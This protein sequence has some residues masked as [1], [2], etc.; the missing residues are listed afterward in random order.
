MQTD[1]AALEPESQVMYSE[2]NCVLLDSQYMA[3]L[4]IDRVWAGLLFFN[5]TSSLKSFAF[6]PNISHPELGTHVHLAVHAHKSFKACIMDRF[7]TF[8]KS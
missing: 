7:L 2:R 8:Q 5:C 6:N 4:V 1:A 3:R